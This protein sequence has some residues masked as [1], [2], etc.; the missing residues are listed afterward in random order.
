MV[1]S[2]ISRSRPASSGGC[3]PAPGA[4]GLL[5]RSIESAQQVRRHVTQFNEFNG[6]PIK[7][8]KSSN[9][10][11][12]TMV[13]LRSTAERLPGDLTANDA[14]APS[15][16]PTARRSSAT[17]KPKFARRSYRNRQWLSTARRDHQGGGRRPCVGCGEQRQ[18]QSWIAASSGST[19]RY[20][21]LEGCRRGAASSKAIP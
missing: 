2:S 9:T 18:D 15:R 17:R 20:S 5:R 6:Y 11:A 14:T 7:H 16:P 21:A 13:R 1:T 12:S 10:L 19:M 8:N 4:Y 3:K